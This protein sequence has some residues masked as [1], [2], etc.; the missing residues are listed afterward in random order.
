MK[1]NNQSYLK[2]SNQNVILDYIVKHGPTSRAELSKQLGVSKPTISTNV[3]YLIENKILFEDGFSSPTVGK[4]A[5][6]IH[7]NKNLNYVLVCDQISE[8]LNNQILISLCN[9][10]FEEILTEKIS[11]SL[12]TSIDNLNYI[13]NTQ[14]IL[15]LKDNNIP[16]EKISKVIIAASGVIEDGS[17]C[18]K[19]EKGNVFDI[20][21]I[22]NVNFKD[23]VI[24]KNDIKLASICVKHFGIGCKYEN[25]AFVWA[26]L[27]LSSSLILNGNLYNG[28]NFASGEIGLLL[29][30][31]PFT[32]E[33][34]FLSELASINGILTNIVKYNNVPKTSILYSQIENNSLTFDHI[35][36]GVQC[37]D[38]Y[39]LTLSKL[40]GSK[41]GEALYNLSLSLDL[42]AIVMSG[43][44]CDLG[45]IFISN[46]ESFLNI[47]P[48]N[49]VVLK[50][51]K[52]PKAII[53]GGYKVGVDCTIK[54]LV[55]DL[56]N[57]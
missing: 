43:E 14:I 31:S 17:L 9:L 23:K 15:K 36:K 33:I 41:L 35:I 11:I 28:K 29:T 7:F 55:K 40:I 10:N 1:A 27:A 52:N 54:S 2:F 6:L 4:K 5:L 18:I 42:E 46:I 56:Y 13:L 24:L 39:C 34:C 30:S 22:C 25:I 12:D 37:S 32:N 49:K 26:G 8:I 16:L 50:I 44:L 47:N 20:S 53:L 19:N 57:K 3:N 21:E 51:S 48:L 45:P 38:A